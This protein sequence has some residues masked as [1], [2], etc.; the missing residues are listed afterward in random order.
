M[1]EILMAPT[2]SDLD[3]LSTLATVRRVGRRRRIASWW[4]V[5][6]PIVWSAS[7]DDDDRRLA[8]TTTTTPQRGALTEWG[9]HN[10]TEQCTYRKCIE[11]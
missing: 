5:W 9:V 2:D 11:R 1:G 6:P 3:D 4:G 8:K 7:S 10:G